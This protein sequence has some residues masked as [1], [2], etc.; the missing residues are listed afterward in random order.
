M[1]AIR[2]FMARILEPQSLWIGLGIAS[3]LLALAVF[4]LMV[5]RWG[6]VRPLTKCAFLSVFAHL[7]LLWFAYLFQWFER[8]LPI[9]VAMGP[10]RVRLESGDAADLKGDSEL[11]ESESPDAPQVAPLAIEPPPLE[12]EVSE[13]P[14]EVAEPDNFPPSPAPDT[15]PKTDVV[16]MPSSPL[17]EP[18]PEPE[19]KAP[20]SVAANPTT[21]E[22]ADLLAD[23]QTR[24]SQ[25]VETKVQQNVRADDQS[26][27]AAYERRFD[28]QRSQLV[29]KY[30]GSSDTESV[31]TSALDYL[32]RSQSPDGR[33]D[34]SALEAGR[35]SGRDGQSR[36]PAGRQ[37]DS[38]ISGLALLAFLGAG[39]THLQ[40]A[41]Q[42]TVSRGL[43]F[44]LG[45]QGKDGNLS[46]DEG[47]YGAMYCHGMS[48]F[49]LAE[50]Y[51]ITGDTRL[52]MAVK[53]GVQ[54]TI[55]AQHP[56]SG[57]WR[58]QPWRKRPDDFGDMSQFGWHI[59]SLYSARQA[60]VEIPEEVS[61]RGRK[62]LESC[63]Q[64][65]NFGGL[66]VYQPGRPV[67]AS[68]TAEALLMRHLL[69]VHHDRQRREAAEYL[70]AFRPGYS[71][72]DFY[73]WYYGTLAMFQ[74]Q[75][76]AWHAWNNAL[77]SELSSLQVA[78]GA[79][80]GSWSP[81][82]VWG[83]YGGR[84]Y[85]TSLAALSLEVYYRYSPM[86]ALHSVP[87]RR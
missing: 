6:R 69:Q 51:A 40:G 22:S 9:H 37:A 33:W 10:V 83:S 42:S 56:Q 77:V 72:P 68:M 16:S 24:L 50:A 74:L 70:L 41:Y 28:T 3:G 18:R 57:G 46:G 43:E 15:T 47:H 36:G 71:E 63:T 62:F 64:Q 32:A 21:D 48:L 55:E 60:G 78:R 53:R 31:V 7:L 14:P 26:L 4:V 80:A 1:L 66:A 73:L 29:E 85:S 49:A 54:Y 61:D 11:V 65:G 59:M 34:A 86:T 67:S 27:P 13:D 84:V 81:D 58:Y 19:Q 35:E 20:Q 79:Q 25:V 38:G 87:S 82:T 12:R 5:S 39:N 2:Q 52:Q 17:Q 75:G 45:I 23:P 30:G 44:L 8:P 76:P